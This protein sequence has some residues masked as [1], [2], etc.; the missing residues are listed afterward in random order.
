[1]A[2]IRDLDDAAAGSAGVDDLGIE[3]V[4]D[5]RAELVAGGRI[6]VERRDRAEVSSAARGDRAGVLLR[7]V[8]PVW[9]RVVRRDV[10]DLVGGLVVPRAPGEAA[11]ERDCRALIDAEQH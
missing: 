10:I 2:R 6:P 9:K 1:A 11:V 8:D 3:R 7:G 4:G 5:Y